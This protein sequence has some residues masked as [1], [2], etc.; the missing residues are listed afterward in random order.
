MSSITT[1]QP[2]KQASVEA[3]IIRA[4]GTVVDLG[5]IAYYHKNP[6]KRLGWRISQIFNRANRA[7]RE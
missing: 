1:S 6:F 5:V 4:D 7:K 3:K 2:V